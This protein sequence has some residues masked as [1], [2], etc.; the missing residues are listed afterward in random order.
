[1][2]TPVSSIIGLGHLATLNPVNGESKDLFEKVLQSAH[3]MDRLLQKLRIISEINQP[4]Q[5]SDVEI[6]PVIREIEQTFSTF[7]D[8]HRI[9]VAITCGED[10]RFHSNRTLTEAILFYLF[11][12]AIFFSSIE[13]QGRPEVEFSA[14]MANGMI[15]FSVRD[16]GIGIDE[17]IR[18]NIYDMFYVGY[19]G[20]R[21]N[22]LGLYIVGKAVQ[23]LKGTIAAESEVN[24][25]T[26]FVV[27]LPADLTAIEPS[28][29][30]S[31]SL[32]ATDE[33]NDSFT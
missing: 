1:L 28:E 25:F 16:N 33:A 6:L 8:D 15:E 12:N 4:G 18:N 11:E 23:A 24:R 2:R 20:S 10:V 3:S 14:R 7:I 31:D 27:T 29:S 19:E 13:N 17:K 21:G 22:G 26:R 32:V 9:N 5:Y 30:A